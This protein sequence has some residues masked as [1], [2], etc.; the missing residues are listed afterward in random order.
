MGTPWDAETYDRTSA[1][2]QSWASDVLERLS[3]IAP[4]A[5]VLDVGCG[6]GRVD[7]AAGGAPPGR[8]HSGDRRLA[9]DD[10]A[11]GGAAGRAGGGSLRGRSGARL[12][13]SVDAVFSTAALHWVP[14]HRLMWQRLAAALRPG[15]RLEIQCG[16][17]GN[18]ARVRQAIAAAVAETA[19]ELEGFSPWTFAG[20][21]ET[22]R[23]LLESGFEQIELLA[24]GAPD[25]APMTPRRLCAR[26]SWLPTSSASRQIAASPSREPFSSGSSC[27]WTM[28]G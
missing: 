18:I 12:E 8:A 11:C 6:T 25:A 24:A 20:P 21:E 28:C 7:R 4:D 27:R 26:R 2:Q 17:E 10:R 1:P 23:R 3:G 19:P 13:G 5:T 15:G 22:Q 16:G 14:D 9:G